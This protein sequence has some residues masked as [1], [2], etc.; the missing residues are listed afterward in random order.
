MIHIIHQCH[1]KVNGCR[2]E[3]MYTL[4][5]ANSKN[6]VLYRFR[7]V[8]Y[9]YRI[10]PSTDTHTVLY[11]Y[12]VVMDCTVFVS[13]LYC[14]LDDDTKTILLSTVFLQL[15]SNSIVFVS[16]FYCIPKTCTSTVLSRTVFILVIRYPVSV[17]EWYRNDVQ[18]R[19]RS[20]PFH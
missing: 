8:L 3:R 18:K 14:M 16:A 13:D 2:Y 1:F 17:L 6:W 10:Q 5:Q 20:V 4:L 7:S 19:Y 15:V 12:W 9:S 11:M